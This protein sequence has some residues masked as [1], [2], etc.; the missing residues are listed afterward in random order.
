MKRQNKKGFTIIEL[1][2]VIAVIAILA[3]VLIPVFSNIV[4]KANVSKDTQLVR[5][6]NTALKTDSEEHETM[7]DA[8]QAAEEYGYN[9]AKINASAT[10]NEILW[11]SKN[12]C[13]VYLNGGKIEYIPNSKTH[14]NVADHEYWVISKTVS[15]KYSTYY[16]G[17]ANIDSDTQTSIC[18]ATNNTNLVIDA[19]NADVYHYGDVAD[20]TIEA[21]AAN[22]YHEF[23]RV[24]GLA[25]VKAGHVV[26]ENGGSMGTVVV[27]S[28]SVSLAG[29]F[30]MIMGTNEVIAALGTVNGQTVTVADNAVENVSTAVAIVDGVFYDDFA[31]ALAAANGKEA[32]L[33]RDVKYAANKVFTI[34]KNTTVTIDLNGHAIMATAGEGKASNVITN[35]GN[36]TIKDSVGGGKITTNALNPDMQAIPGFASNTISNYG[37][38]VL[39]SGTIENASNAP[40]AYPVD[41]YQGSTFIMNGGKLLAAKC[42]LRMFC[43]SATDAV[44]VTIN[45]GVIEGGTRGIWVQL[46]SSDNTKAAAGNLTINGG[47]INGGTGLS[48]YVYSFGNNHTA[49]YVTITGGVFNNDVAF[50]AG[51]YET[52]EIV[53][54]TGG[55]F[56]GELG[57]YLENDGWEDIQKP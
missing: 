7:Y 15:E 56:N 34:S 10:D 57:R 49:T 8:L 54:I 44:N 9:V 42:A 40:A 50:G 43:N 13:F 3:S 23:G 48:L 47:T 5:N 37:T 55:T 16:T 26:V 51:Y 4:D 11:D 6:L 1:V 14:D 32:V 31:D 29:D 25:T 27:T 21:V 52:Q 36:L 20:L 28:T 2:I 18:V 38:L 45:G 35:N 12:D 22:S 46:P 17:S 41:C 53:S 24:T 39:E 30:G 19:P 33:V